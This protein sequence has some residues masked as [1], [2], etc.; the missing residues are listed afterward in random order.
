[1]IFRNMLTSQLLESNLLQFMTHVENLIK[2]I[3][4]LLRLNFT[5]CEKI[6]QFS[7]LFCNLRFF[8][9]YLLQLISF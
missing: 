6:A 5:L 4:D 7:D 3:V 8:G 9:W 1:M 2:L